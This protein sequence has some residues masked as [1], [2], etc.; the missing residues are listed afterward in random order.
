LNWFKHFHKEKLPS[1]IERYYNETKRV[2]G[3]I[4]GQLKDKEYITGTYGIADMAFYPWVQGSDFGGIVKE[5]D[6]FKKEFPN[7][8][9]WYHRV[10]ERPATV[11]AFKD[12][13]K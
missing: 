3:V 7:L 9:A 12:F 6:E 1:A 2:Y 8:Y 11:R 10:S 5:S 4:E 13:G